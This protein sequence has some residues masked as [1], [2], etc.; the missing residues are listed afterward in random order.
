MMLRGVLQKH[1]NLYLI[2]N[3]LNRKNHQ[4]TCSAVV[5]ARVTAQGYNSEGKS[6][7]PAP[8]SYAAGNA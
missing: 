4:I 2:D 6:E 7:D 5:G 8:A 3:Q 1:I